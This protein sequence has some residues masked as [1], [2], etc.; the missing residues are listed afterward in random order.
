VL[1]WK[2]AKRASRN[3]LKAKIALARAWRR[4]RRPEPP[5]ARATTLIMNKDPFVDREQGLVVSRYP[6]RKAERANRP[7]DFQKKNKSAR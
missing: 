1:P 7:Q 6:D 5:S 4:V 2:R 3:R